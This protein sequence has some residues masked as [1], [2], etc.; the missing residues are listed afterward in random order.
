MFICNNNKRKS[1]TVPAVSQILW[2]PNGQIIYLAISKPPLVFKS[3]LNRVNN[4]DFLFDVKV[5]KVGFVLDMCLLIGYVPMLK[6]LEPCR[7]EPVVLIQ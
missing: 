5:F 1:E 7:R 4:N 6:I 2:F 3:F